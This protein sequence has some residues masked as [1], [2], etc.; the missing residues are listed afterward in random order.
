MIYR[1]GIHGA[2]KSQSGCTR[3]NCLINC[4]NLQVNTVKT[5]R[6]LTMIISFVVLMVSTW[7][8]VR[9]IFK[10]FKNHRWSVPLRFLAASR[11]LHKRS[12]YALCIK[13]RL[14]DKAKVYLFLRL[15]MV[16]YNLLHSHSKARLL[17]VPIFSH[18]QH[19]A[20]LFTVMN[21]VLFLYRV[22]MKH[23]VFWAFNSYHLL[24]LDNSLTI[25]CYH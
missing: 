25:I 12:Y 1:V 19:G 22:L 23:C 17:K 11:L 16:E 14:H 10:Q 2:F 4:T 15:R 7:K 8:S 3:L 20:Y 21:P 9:P 13:K 18:S 6:S 24:C 5:K